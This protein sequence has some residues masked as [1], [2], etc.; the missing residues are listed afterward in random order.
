MD[1][2]SASINPLTK[3]ISV[4]FFGANRLTDKFV[5]KK[6]GLTTKN[7]IKICLSEWTPQILPDIKILN[8]I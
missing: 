1:L 3:Q 4:G 2:C 7:S 8:I 5:T 6:G